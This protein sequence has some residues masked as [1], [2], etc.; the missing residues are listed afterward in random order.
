MRATLQKLMWFKLL[1][2]ILLYTVRADV[3]AFLVGL[4]GLSAAGLYVL[5]DWTGEL[6]DI[7]KEDNDGKK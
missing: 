6:D 3:W 5:L 4:S 7:D 2:A 1:L